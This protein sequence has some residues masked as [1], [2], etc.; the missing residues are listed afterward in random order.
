MTNEGKALFKELEL[1]KN[2]AVTLYVCEVQVPS[3]ESCNNKTVFIDNRA[4]LIAVFEGAKNTG[5]ENV[6]V[7][8][9]VQSDDSTCTGRSWNLLLGLPRNC[10]LDSLTLTI[11]NFS[12]R[13]TELSFTQISFLESS[14]SLKSL[15]LTLNEYNKHWRD[16]YVSRLR[17]G[18]GRNISLISLTLT[19]NIYTRPRSFGSVH[20]QCIPEYLEA[21]VICNFAVVVF[22]TSQ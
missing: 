7:T 22:P 17:E 2:P 21:L 10:T 11:N 18:L 19:L 4:S 8:I 15:N 13:S 20:L 14:I 16:T 9:I 3:D 12:P 5:K 1:D 6:T